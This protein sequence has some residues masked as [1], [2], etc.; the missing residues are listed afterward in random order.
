MDGRTT[1]EILTRNERVVSGSV[2]ETCVVLSS[3]R[4]LSSRLSRRWTE[5]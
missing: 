3:G 4:V 5:P 1:V 2:C